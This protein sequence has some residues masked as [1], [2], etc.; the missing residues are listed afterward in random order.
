M[1]LFLCYF[2][3]D[4]ELN[5]IIVHELMYSRLVVL[6]VDEGKYTSE[7]NRIRVFIVKDTCRH[8]RYKRVRRLSDSQIESIDTNSHYM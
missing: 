3:R 8:C 5:A 7:T 6:F 1:R 2:T 4:S